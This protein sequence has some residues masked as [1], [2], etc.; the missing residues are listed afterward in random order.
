MVPQ[1]GICHK[2]C[3]H[4]KIDFPLYVNI[5]KKTIRG[6]NLVKTEPRIKYFA[7]CTNTHYYKGLT[8]VKV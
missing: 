7:S 8:S 5:V 3:H 2:R 6:H 1:L 4:H